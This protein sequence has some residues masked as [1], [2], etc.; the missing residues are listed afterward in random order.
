[1][2]TRYAYGQLV[3]HDAIRKPLYYMQVELWDRDVGPDDKLGQAVSDDEGRFAIEYDSGDAGW[4]ERG[5]PDLYLKIFHTPWVTPA[6]GGA[7]QPRMIAKIEGPGDFDNEHYNFG[8]VRVPHWEYDLSFPFPS[9]LRDPS[10]GDL[11]Q[12]FPA[13][14]LAYL[15]AANAKTIAAAAAITAASKLGARIPSLGHVQGAFPTNLTQQLRHEVTRGDDF[16]VY[17]LFNGFNPVVPCVDPDVEDGYYV[18]Y[19]WDDYESDG[20]HDLPNAR[21]SFVMRDGKPLP[22][23]IQLWF[24]EPGTIDAVAPTGPTYDAR[25]GG[26]AAAQA[27][28]LQA[29]RVFRCVW[30]TAGEMDTHLCAAHLNVAQYAIAAFRNFERNPVRKLL[31]PHLREVVK[32][33]DLGASAIF[34]VTGVLTTNTPLTTDACWRRLRHHLGMR[35]WTDWSPRKPIYAGH[36]YAKAAQLFWGVVTQH[37]DAFFAQN[38]AEILAHWHEVERFS[39]DL[40]KHSVAYHHE[41]VSAGH[42]Y[43]DN[44]LHA[45]RSAAERETVDG[46]VRSVRKITRAHNVPLDGEVEKLKQISRYAIFHATFFHTWA[47]DLQITDGGELL[48]ETLALRNGSMGSEDDHELAPVPAECARQLALSHVLAASKRGTIMNNEDNDI[49]QRFIDLLAGIRDEYAAL[50]N[51]FEVDE[52]FDIEGIRSR[53]NI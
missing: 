16:F 43:D 3:H 40:V 50:R 51:P 8:R 37:V 48:Y 1:M 19:N 36:T 39:E 26:D 28:W 10:S 14:Y 35:D 42:P 18:E 47:N 29:K 53:I 30:L 49:P 41:H 17:R 7:G 11:P 38:E 24:R 13:G 21:A 32:I 4:V 2:A 20:F 22:T 34:G 25:P 9:V 33:N 23:R 27:L 31:F 45:S 44:E 5:R 12:D 15:L 46:S 6:D 52:T